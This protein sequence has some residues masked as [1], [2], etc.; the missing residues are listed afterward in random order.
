MKKQPKTYIF[1]MGIAIFTIGILLR[2]LVPE[3]TGALR[4][5]PFVLTGFGAGIVGVGIANL[6]RKRILEK[7]PE[8]A[9]EYEIAEKD[10]RNVRLR[11]KAGY[12]TWYIT[13]FVLAVLALTF[14]VLDYS[15]ACW[16]TI[17][18][19]FTH[20]FSLIVFIAIYNKKI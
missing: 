20:I 9:K 2:F 14:I 7:N 17:G 4:S 5:L 18:A 11:E 1:Y 13:L 19:L 3:A 16:L 15:V 6:F 10:E 8:K 12:A